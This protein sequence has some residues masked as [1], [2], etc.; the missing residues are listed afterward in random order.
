MA[1]V[2]AV[3]FTHCNKA[4]EG[5]VI[6]SPPPPPPK[7]LIAN[8]GADTTIFMPYGGSGIVFKAILNGRASKDDAGNIVT[9]SWTEIENEGSPYS[10]AKITDQYGDSTTATFH[11]GSGLHIFHLEVRDDRG[12]VDFAR[13]SVNFIS[14]F[15]FAYDE[16]SWDRYQWFI[17]H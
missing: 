3:I 13:I 16:L 6:S 11:S 7:H 8:A 17:N 9:Y 4:S 1:I 12:R 15:D 14:P 5:I 10:L 2:T